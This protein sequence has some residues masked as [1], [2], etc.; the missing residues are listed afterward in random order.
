[1][2]VTCVCVCATVRAGGVRVS[3]KIGEGV[4]GEVY[5]ASHDGHSVALKVFHLPVFPH[6]SLAV[7]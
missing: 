6:L 1:V 7:D 2:I 3:K 4:Y 5:R